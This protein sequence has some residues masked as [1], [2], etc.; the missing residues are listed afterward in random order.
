EHGAFAA[1]RLPRLDVEGDWGVN[2]P[3]APDAIPTYQVAVAVTLPLVNG[4]RREASLA[5]KDA[6]M[7]EAKVRLKDLGR[8]VSAEVDGARIDVAS[9]LELQAVANEA[10]GLA[11]RAVEQAR[12]RLVHGLATNP[13]LIEP[14]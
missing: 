10:P 9:G 5:E 2:G 4:G 13:E 1:E 14:Q 8:Q 12:D 7:R 6:E 3:T 11:Q